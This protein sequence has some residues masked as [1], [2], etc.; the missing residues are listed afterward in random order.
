MGSLTNE[1]ILDGD[2]EVEGTVAG[3][4]GQACCEGNV[5]GIDEVENEEEKWEDQFRVE[6]HSNNYEHVHVTFS[7][8]RER[9]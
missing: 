1:E 8:H 3:D 4:A 2:G 6:E 5:D 7:L 9:S